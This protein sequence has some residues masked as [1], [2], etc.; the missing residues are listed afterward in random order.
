[1]QGAP[2]EIVSVFKELS[3]FVL[4]D[5]S[6]G[7]HIPRATQFLTAWRKVFEDNFNLLTHEED[8]ASVGL[9]AR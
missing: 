2:V 6:V 5:S 8:S 4:L 1:M 9:V 3:A 7:I